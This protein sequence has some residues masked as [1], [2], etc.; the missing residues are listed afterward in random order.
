MSFSGLSNNTVINEPI[1]GDEFELICALAILKGQEG[2]V[3][4]EKIL[5]T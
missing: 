5:P 1:L 2:N 4:R 3:L